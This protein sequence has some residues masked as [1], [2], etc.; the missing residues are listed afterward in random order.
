MNKKSFL[1]MTKDTDLQRVAHARHHDPFTVLG[2]HPDAGQ[3][4]LT[5]F[6]PF[7]EK[8]WVTTS[9]GRTELERVE[10]TA[11]FTLSGDRTLWGQHPLLVEFDG[12]Y[13]CSFVDPYSFWPQLAEDALHQFHA[14]ECFTAHE[15]LGARRHCVDGVDGILFAVWAPNA[16]RVSVVGDFNRW[17]G[18]V[19]AMRTRGQSGVWELFIPG[20]AVHSLYKFELRQRD[21]GAILLKSDPY[22]RSF[23]M[24]PDTASVIAPASDYAWQDDLWMRRRRSHDWLHQPMSV[25][26]VHLGSWKRHANGDYFSYRDL[27]EQLVPYVKDMGFTHLELLPMTEYPYDGSWGYQ[28][29]GYFAPS[30]RFGSI[31]DFKYFVDCC[32]RHG[33]GVLLDWVPAHFPKD[34]HGLA[35]FD[36]TPLYEH[37]DPRRGEHK[38]WGTLIFNYGRNE[39]RNFLFSSAYFWLEE[40][41]IDGLRV[42]AVASMLYLDYSREPGEWTPNQYGGNENLDAIHFIR[43]TNE[44]VHQAFP[45]VLMVAEESTAWPQVSRPVYLGGLGFSMKWNMGWMND[46]LSYFSQDPVHRQY[47]HD[48]LTFSLLYAFSENFVLPLSHDEVVHGKRSLLEKMPGDGWQKFA[49]L[50]L[51]FTYLYTHPGKKLLFMGG[52]FGQ[53][54]EW[55]HDQSLDWHLLDHDLQRGA[56]SAVRDLNQLYLQ[57]SPL[58][59]WDFDWRGFEWVD[60]HDHSQS[61]VSF[62]RKSADGYLLVV[63]NFTPVVREHYRIGVPEAGTYAEC[64]NSDS[65][66]YG[67]SNVSNGT[68]IQSQPVEAMGRH[69]SVVLTLPPLAGIVLQKTL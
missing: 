39:V 16:E 13:E 46:T 30:S 68:A 41:H 51:L 66:Y 67:G 24:R 36:G 38:D 28:V 44:V 43:R 21:S 45:G 55:N 40:F 27:A 18:R 58:H 52:E 9:T 34:A 1:P 7:A 10:G 42:D 65:E 8:M 62:L 63:L 53:G 64:F 69:H 6:R 29:T 54:I 12:A 56:Q 15:L 33:I 32:H 37:E 20:L 61:I 59:Q 5:V 17:D 4:R 47:H 48:K 31:D 26:E 35:R 14:G 25:Y 23:Q 2:V 60:C 49:N 3:W 57:R 22:G 50:R 19:H 11:F